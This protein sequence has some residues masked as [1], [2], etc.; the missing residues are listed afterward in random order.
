MVI[1]DEFQDTNP[2]QMKMVEAI[3]Q[4]AKGAKLLMVGDFDQNIYEWRGT[5][6]KY[7]SEYIATHKPVLKYLEN[8]YRMGQAVTDISQQL[9][10]SFDFYKFFRNRF[11]RHYSLH[12]RNP[13]NA[14]PEVRTFESEYSEVRWVIDQ[15]EQHMGEGI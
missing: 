1:V 9:I 3:L 6:L 7:L 10:R 13:L 14:V 5:D 8:S 15:I 4:R 11:Y 12:S 2:A